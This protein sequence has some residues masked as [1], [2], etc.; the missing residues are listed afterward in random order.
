MGRPQF[1][2]TP[3]MLDTIYKLVLIGTPVEDVAYVIG[4][5]RDTIDK[6][7]EASEQV[8][9]ARR[10]GNDLLRQTAFKMATSGDNTAMTIFLCKVRLGWKDQRPDPTT[11]TNIQVNTNVTNLDP[12]TVKA[13]KDWARANAAIEVN[14]NEA[15]RLLLGA[16]D[17][18][19]G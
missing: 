8:V 5:S 12:Q 19:E 17:D 18:P 13:I 4:C 9:K 11:Q 6:N 7:A 14:G 10:E 3:E 1:N 15:E 16:S 2:F